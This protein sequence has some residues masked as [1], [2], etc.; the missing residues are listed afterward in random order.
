MSLYIPLAYFYNREFIALKKKN[1]NLV[2]FR[3]T[4][5]KVCHKKGSSLIYNRSPRHER[6]E[7]HECNTSATRV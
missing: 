7:R 4:Y 3:S 6:H 1:I 5:Q 2:T